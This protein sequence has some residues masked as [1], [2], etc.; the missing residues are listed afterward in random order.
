M[1]HKHAN[2]CKQKQLYTTRKHDVCLAQVEVPVLESILTREIPKDVTLFVH[3]SVVCTVNN[4]GS[5]E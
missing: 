2:V 1:I 5:T 4:L 3:H